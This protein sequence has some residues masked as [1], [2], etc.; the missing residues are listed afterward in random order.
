MRERIDVL[1]KKKLAA[2]FKKLS[3]EW[4]F[5]MFFCQRCCGSVLL[6]RLRRFSSKQGCKNW[7]QGAIAACSAFEETPSKR[8][9]HKVGSFISFASLGLL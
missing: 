2:A 4:C 1:Y 6:C 7:R 8:E 3:H 9:C 5:L